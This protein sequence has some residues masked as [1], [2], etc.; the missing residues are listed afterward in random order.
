M[1]LYIKIR[2]FLKLSDGIGVDMFDWPKFFLCPE[3]HLRKK[4][5]WFNFGIHH[6]PHSV[7]IFKKL[8]KFPH[9]G[10]NQRISKKPFLPQLMLLQGIGHMALPHTI[11]LPNLCFDRQ[12]E[13]LNNLLLSALRPIFDEKLGILDRASRH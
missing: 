10:L 3:M 13:T 6:P 12:I 1:D 4:Y 2:T 5:G 9:F 7:Y 11:Q 8:T